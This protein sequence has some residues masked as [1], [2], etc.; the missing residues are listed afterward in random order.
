MIVGAG[1]RISLMERKPSSSEQ[2]R[3]SK[4]ERSIFLLIKA[5]SLKGYKLHSRD[6]EIGK[7]EQF[8]LR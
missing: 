5:K 8:L 4:K 1:F 2:K 6:G 3:N 7:V